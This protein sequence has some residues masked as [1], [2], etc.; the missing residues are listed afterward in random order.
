MHNFNPTDYESTLGPANNGEPTAVAP[1]EPAKPVVEPAAVPAAE[2]TPATPVVA[3]EHE[4]DAEGKVVLDED[5]QPKKKMGG[6]QKRIERLNRKLMEK[7]QEL[8]FLR[9]YA[10]PQ[11][12]GTPRPADVPTQPIAEPTRDK[13]ETTE[14]FVQALVK[15]QTAMAITEYQRNQDKAAAQQS[16]QQLARRFQQ[17]IIQAPVKY[18]DWD[19]VMEDTTAPSTPVMDQVIKRSE[20]AVDMMYFLAKNEAEATRIAQLSDPMAQTMAMGALEEQFRKAGKTTTTETKPT[21]QPSAAPP[22]I[23]PV[24]ASTQHVSKSVVEMDGDEYLMHMRTS[25]KK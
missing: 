10:T 15:H 3:E 25:K 1:T 5:G 24:N 21:P 8:E 9:R 6:F 2:P 7:D 17:Q 19:D 4:L 11:V 14:E 20:F 18:K 23:T 13:F 12:P 22:P 16:E